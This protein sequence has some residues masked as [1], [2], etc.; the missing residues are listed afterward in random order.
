MCETESERTQHSTALRAVHISM[1]HFTTAAAGRQ[2]GSR[3]KPIAVDKS[4]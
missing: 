1:N 2:A 4:C 3:N